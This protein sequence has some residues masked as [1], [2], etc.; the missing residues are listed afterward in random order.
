V[1]GPAQP[2]RGNRV[3]S[4]MHPLAPACAADRVEWRAQRKGW[5]V[6]SGSRSWRA[7]CSRRR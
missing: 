4:H 6:V 1:H 2:R 7:R 3:R 5:G